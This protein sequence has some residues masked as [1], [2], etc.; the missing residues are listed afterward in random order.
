MFKDS[1]FSDLKKSLHLHFRVQKLYYIYLEI[2]S[3]FLRHRIKQGIDVLEEDW[4]NLIVLDAC[5]YDSFKKFNSFPGSLEKK[6]SKATSTPQWLARN[7]TDYYDDIVFVA[8]NPYVS[9]LAGEGFFDAEEHFHHVDHVW[10]HSWDSDKG[11]VTPDQ[12]YYPL[13]PAT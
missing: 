10:D 9:H 12:I 13:S 3:I 11:T 6:F 8:G 4:D 1:S 7:F 5:R 2:V